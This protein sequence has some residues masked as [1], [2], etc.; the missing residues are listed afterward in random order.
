MPTN[1]M[2]RG[3]FV[4][5][6]EAWFFKTIIAYLLHP[7]PQFT[8]LLLYIE[9]LTIDTD[10][11]ISYK[12]ST[13]SHLIDILGQLTPQLRFSP[14]GWLLCRSVRSLWKIGRMAHSKSSD[15][16][17]AV[18]IFRASTV[19][20]RFV[21]LLYPADFLSSRLFGES[22]ETTTIYIPYIKTCK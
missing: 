7:F 6:Q 22:E 13:I 3:I 14:C 20:W 12:Y 8:L 9:V 18:Y 17:L 5:K 2:K 1:S 15:S 4:K 10:F 11:D 16:E 21:S 19:S